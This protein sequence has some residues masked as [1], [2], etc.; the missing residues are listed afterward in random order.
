V[1]PQ[2]LGCL[3]IHELRGVRRV[4]RIVEVEAYRGDGSDAA[5]HAHRGPTPRNGAMFGP[6]GHFYVYRSMGLH[7][8]VNVV[9]EPEGRAAAVLLRAAEPLDG[10]EAIRRARPGRSRRELT[11]GPGKLTQAFAIRAH[12]NGRSALRGPLRIVAAR[13]TPLQEV[14]AGPR[15]G[16]RKAIELP[17]RF[18]LTDHPDVTRSPL[19]RAAQALA[20]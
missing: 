1:A 3:L 2:L 11:N 14:R 15:I 6:P 19:N 8:C 13:E 16:I 20:R 4:G 5:S 17:Y 7:F 10:L 18:F 9:C 12:H